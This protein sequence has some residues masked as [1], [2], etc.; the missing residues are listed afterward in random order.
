MASGPVMRR[1]FVRFFAAG[2]IEIIRAGGSSPRFLSPVVA[3]GKLFVTRN[4]RLIFRE[5]IP[6][7]AGHGR[8]NE[9]VR[10]PRCDH[11]RRKK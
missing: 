11:F 5:E 8:L 2:Q 9:R 4:R 1:M 6:A 3:G 7:F 10:A